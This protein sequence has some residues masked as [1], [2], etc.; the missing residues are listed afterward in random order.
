M[1]VGG[2]SISTWS[3]GSVYC[4]TLS[5]QLF[6]HEQYKKAQGGEAPIM[7]VGLSAARPDTTQA[8]AASQRL[9]IQSMD[10]E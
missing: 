10:S 6:Q 2:G 5:V 9:T 1:S 8:L 4:P 3:L 7:L